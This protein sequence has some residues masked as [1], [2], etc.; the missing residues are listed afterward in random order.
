MT[1]NLKLGKIWGIP[2]GLHWSWFLIFGLMTWSLATG[3]FPS[4]YPEVPALAHWVLGAV[5][6][7]L[8]FASV[9]LHELGHAYEALRHKLPVRRI[10]LFIFGGVAEMAED[11]RSPREEFRVAIAGPLVSLALSG[12]FYV[13]W[14]LD[15][16]ISTYLAIP[17]IW[18]ARINLMLALFNL[19]PGF[20][21][22]GGRVLRAAVWAWTGNQLQATRIASVSGQ[23][24]AFGFMGV[25][26]FTIVGGNTLNGLWLIFIGWF[27]QN[28]AATSFAQ[29]SLRH[30]LRDV[31]VDQVMQPGYVRIQPQMPIVQLVADYV[32]NGGYDSFIV[33]ENGRI[34]GIVTLT[35]VAR[36]ARDKWS[37]TSVEEIM[38]DPG[39]LVVL[40][41]EASLLDALETMEQK[42]I[43]QLPILRSDKASGLSLNSE[44]IL[45]IL[46]KHHIIHYIGRRAKL[47][48]N[49]S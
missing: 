34:Q 36:V 32:L 23:L 41:Q 17:S 9:L 13:V 27:L 18:L 31:R 6:A 38:T 44:M 40:G 29:T 42:T 49:A 33:E 37:V 26:V 35:D 16:D 11:T 1:S 22:D 47:G 24:V 12:I 25:G 4:E 20:P 30:A 2:I 46:S 19:I 43:N 39:R 5:T 7:I 45:G 48:L 28:A 10:N 3:F 8:L 21:L 14:L 15:R